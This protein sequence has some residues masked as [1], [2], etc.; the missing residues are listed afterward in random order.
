MH[1]ERHRR[2]AGGHEHVE[3]RAELNRRRAS[4]WSVAADRLRALLPK[5]VAA[6]EAAL[7]ADPADARLALELLKL[8]DIGEAVRP[9]GPATAAD[10]EVADASAVAGRQRA[11]L[12]NALAW[13]ASD[14]RAEAER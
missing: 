11:Q 7:D 3:F 12:S 13:V 10:V 8:A 2:V 6:L 14:A 1:G 9:V 5:A 4:L